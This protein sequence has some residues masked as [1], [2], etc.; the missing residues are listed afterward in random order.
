[1]SRFLDRALQRKILSGLSEIYPVG[2][3]KFAD[4]KSISGL[5]DI[6]DDALM[7]N[8]TYLSEHGLLTNGFKRFG[9]LSDVNFQ[10]VGE[11]KI[12]ASGLDFLQADGGLSAILDTVT[13]RIDSRQFAEM[14][15]ARI[16]SDTNISH[17]KRSEIAAVVRSL[18]AKAIEKLSSKAIDWAVENLPSALPQLQM[19]LG[20]VAG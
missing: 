13:I 6:D 16:E 7:V 20:Q 2:V 11:T 12:T 1:M 4:L 17:E 10:H 9:G 18:P 15:A 19:W 3:L 5:G 8:I 14:L